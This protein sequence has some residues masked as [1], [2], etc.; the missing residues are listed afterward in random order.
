[1][2]D[3]IDPEAEGEAIHVMAGSDPT[4]PEGPVWLAPRL[5]QTK[6]VRVEGML[7]Y[8]D[9]Y[10]ETV[11][12]KLT[13]CVRRSIP[14]NTPRFDFAVAHEVAEWHLRRLRF[15]SERREDAANA[16]AAAILAP[17]PAYRAAVRDHGT[18]FGELAADFR[19]SQVCAA[20][21]FGETMGR[22]IAV[23]TPAQV[24]IRG[25]GWAWPASERAIRRL[26][27]ALVPELVRVDLTDA[28]GRWALLA[29]A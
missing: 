28:R 9:G 8:G 15:F 25:E 13:V 24:R 6:V 21:R 19:L 3:G 20:L 29:A 7:C 27:L 2:F 12:G 4:D 10:L 17:R 23:V 18:H 26:D 14:V 1:M 22:P 16:I 11:R 5:M